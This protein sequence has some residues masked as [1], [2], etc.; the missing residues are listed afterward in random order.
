MD[1]NSPRMAE[2]GFRASSVCPLS[3][4]EIPPKA[5]QYKKQSFCDKVSG[6]YFLHFGS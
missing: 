4:R 6:F 2:S 3:F 5:V 1:V